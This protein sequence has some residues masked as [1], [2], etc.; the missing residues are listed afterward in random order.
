MNFSATVPTWMIFHIP[1]SRNAPSGKPAQTMPTCLGQVNLEISL[2]L[3]VCDSLD[4]K[5]LA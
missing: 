4:K 1:H 3:I 2:I 5:F